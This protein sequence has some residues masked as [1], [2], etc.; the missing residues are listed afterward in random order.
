MDKF[1]ILCAG[2]TELA[3]FIK[4]IK[5]CKATE[6]A[7]LKFYEG[8]M[9][10]SAA[11][12]VC[13]GVCKV[14]AAAAAQLLI[15]CFGVTVLINAGTAGG[16][17]KDVRLFDTIVS[18]K[19][20]Y[21]DVAEDILT[22]FHPFLTENCFKSDGKLLAA[23]RRYAES[24]DFSVLFGTTV[25]GEQFIEHG[26]RDKISRKYSP[27]SA[28]MES[29]AVAHVCYLNGIP[30][31]SVRTVTDTAEHNGLSNF[32]KNC[33]TASARAAEITAAVIMQLQEPQAA[34]PY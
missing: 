20:I 4:I 1:G 29:A 21:H 13:S 10:K 12:A 25:T 18:E 6:K 30:F 32:E 3:P 23:A 15:D 31:L 27:H 7:M 24:S 34:C 17:D 8:K 9:G 5:P 28:D 19:L 2:D 16:I 11:V 26:E 22:E 14:N 33:E